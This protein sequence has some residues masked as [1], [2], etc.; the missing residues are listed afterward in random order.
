ML[1]SGA[2]AAYALSVKVAG[3]EEAYIQLMNEKAAEL[4]LK[5]TNFVNSSG[6]HDSNHYS[7]VHEMAIIMN[8]AKRVVRW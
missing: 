4:G 1:K 3:S 5:N 7:T 2:D 6:L 8:R